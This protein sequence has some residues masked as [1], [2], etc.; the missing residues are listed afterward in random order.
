MTE[1]VLH[2]LEYDTIISRLAD[3]TTSEISKEMAMNLKPSTDI[4]QIERHLHETMDA[5]SLIFKKGL[6]PFSGI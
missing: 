3:L 4:K 1:K 6:P 5:Q 2:V